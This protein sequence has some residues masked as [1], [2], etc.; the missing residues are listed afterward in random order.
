[1]RP[2][3]RLGTAAMLLALVACTADDR[4]AE[5]SHPVRAPSSTPSVEF[6][7]HVAEILAAVAR[8]SVEGHTGGPAS[9][10]DTLG[11]GDEQQAQIDLDHPDAR[12][13]TTS[14][15]AAVETALTPM[16]VVWIDRAAAAEL[17]QRQLD[18]SPPEFLVLRLA[19]PRISSDSAV[20]TATVWCG[21]LCGSGSTYVLAR[22]DD[23]GWL[24]TGT[25]GSTWIA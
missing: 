15:R 1:M 11:K 18:P 19:F 7:P 22:H 16:D 4:T 13:L 8:V 25:T 12:P 9:I 14:E 21:P 6:V 2:V 10:L 20:V 23:G 17:A 3:R 24:V 5:P